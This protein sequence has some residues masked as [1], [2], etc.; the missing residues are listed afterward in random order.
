[1]PPRR[2]A[3]RGLGRPQLGEQLP[4]PCGVGFARRGGGG[5]AQTHEARAEV[6]KF[7][8]RQ[9]LHKE[10]V[11]VQWMERMRHGKYYALMD[12][13]SMDEK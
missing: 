5:G 9:A 12:T 4:G 6:A 10:R 7:E 1:L 2:L 8:E 13:D 11:S 3:R